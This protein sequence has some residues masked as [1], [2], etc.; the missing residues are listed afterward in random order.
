MVDFADER[1]YM[2]SIS[3]N[4]A[5]SLT[6]VSVGR[7]AADRKSREERGGNNELLG[8]AAVFQR[9]PRWTC[10]SSRSPQRKWDANSRRRLNTLDVNWIKEYAY[11]EPRNLGVLSYAEADLNI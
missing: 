4:G 1:V 7:L 5:E 3:V 8:S 10:F 2:H 11:T 9:S 6:D